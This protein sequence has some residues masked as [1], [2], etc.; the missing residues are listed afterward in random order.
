M[1][2]NPSIN[3]KIQNYQKFV[4]EH[5]PK[6]NLALQMGKAFLVGGIICCLGQFIMNT[7]QNSFSLSAEIAAN[8]CSVLLILLSALL[9]G[10]HLYAGIVKFGGAGALVPITGFANSVV[11][12]AMEYK[13]EGQVF[14]IGCKIFTIAGP[15][16]LY[17]VL[18]SWGLGL[19]YWLFSLL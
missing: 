1:N 9:T 14:G 18:T 12:S 19:L 16:I 6:T 3:R 10:T 7:A 17:G 4:K 11:S 2:Q 15:V 8:W 5:S 13:V